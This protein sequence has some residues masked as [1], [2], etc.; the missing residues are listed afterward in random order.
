[1]ED[2]TILSGMSFGDDASI[3]RLIRSPERDWIVVGQAERASESKLFKAEL[4]HANMHPPRKT[5]SDCERLLRLGN[6]GK[7]LA[8]VRDKK[9][10]IWNTVTG[11]LITQAPFPIPRIDTSVFAPDGTL[12]IAAE[13]SLFPN[14]PPPQVALPKETAS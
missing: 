5:I 13:N 7:E 2:G 11:K 9:V 6:G 4:R 8:V 1:M 10:E 12:V 14:L 3:C